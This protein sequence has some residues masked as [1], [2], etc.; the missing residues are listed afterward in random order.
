VRERV[1]RGE[2]VVFSDKRVKNEYTFHI[3]H[4]PNFRRSPVVP[5]VVAWLKS[6]AA[7]SI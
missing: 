2:L 7:A 1:K 6:E 3:C 4:T 5:E